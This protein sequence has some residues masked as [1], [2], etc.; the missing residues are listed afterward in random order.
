[1]ASLKMDPVQ[2]LGGLGIRCSTNSR[3]R[4]FSSARSANIRSRLQNQRVVNASAHG[5]GHFD[6]E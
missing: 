3:S 6:R 5:I 2:H 4:I 1:M